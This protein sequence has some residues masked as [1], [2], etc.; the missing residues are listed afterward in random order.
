MSETRQDR[1]K[2]IDYM[3][4]HR[5]EYI[6]NGTPE[7]VLN[8]R[9]KE[10]KQYPYYYAYKNFVKAWQANHS[11]SPAPSFSSWKTGYKNNK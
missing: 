3:I 2:Q 10:L 11:I 6:K 7:E 8:E 9:I 5:A 1:Q 4:E